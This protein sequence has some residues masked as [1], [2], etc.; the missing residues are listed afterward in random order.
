MSNI[1]MFTPPAL[2]H[3]IPM[4]FTVNAPRNPGPGTCMT[5]VT[6]KQLITDQNDIYSSFFSVLRLQMNMNMYLIKD[7]MTV[8]KQRISTKFM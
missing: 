8:I 1:K 6:C 2:T 4:S 3:L 5:Y 7:D